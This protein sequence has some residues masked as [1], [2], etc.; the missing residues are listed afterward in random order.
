MNLED[1]LDQR[2]QSVAREKVRDERDADAMNWFNQDQLPEARLLKF[3]TWTRRQLAERLD[4]EWAGAAKEKRI[5]QCRL[6][7]HTVCKELFK[8]GW[9]LDGARLADRIRELLDAV[10]KYQRAGKV[11]DFWA[12][13]KSAVSRYVGANA[14]ELKQEALQ[15]GVH[16][17]NLFAQL[18]KR[19]PSGPSIPELVTQRDGE[20]LRE[21]I[22]RQRAKD[23]HR[24]GDAGQVQLW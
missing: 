18:S 15:C 8:R 23:A 2:E 19:L 5:E 20:S 1:F 3:D 9:M 10:A 7:L 22:A 11:L 17:G 14:E 13:Y 24:K 12:Y 16:V 21:K 6:Q 4:W